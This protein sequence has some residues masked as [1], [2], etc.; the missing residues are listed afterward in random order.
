MS[1]YDVHTHIL[2]GM[3]DGA[4]DV[5]ESIKMLQLLKD[6]GITDVILT[7]HYYPFESPLKNF[8][9]KREECFEKIKDVLAELGLNA[10]IGAEVYFSPMIFAQDDLNDLC[11]DG[12]K[13][14]LL[15]LPFGETNSKKV[16]DILYQL[17]ANYSVRIILAHLNRYPR[18]F[19][20]DFLNELNQMGCLVQVDSSVLNNS[21]KRKC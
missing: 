15:E 6:Q 12:K 19:K 7:P 13:Y 11:I 10:H 14:L 3:D 17:G 20:Y 21:F 16:I 8:L 5:E 4:K 2:P 18:L 9:E 1:Q